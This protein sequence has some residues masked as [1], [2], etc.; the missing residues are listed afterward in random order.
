[1]LSSNIERTIPEICFK[2]AELHTDNF[3]VS[4]VRKKKGNQKTIE[5]KMSAKGVHK[6]YLLSPEAF[7]DPSSPVEKVNRLLLSN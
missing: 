3:K 5:L 2:S 6:K 4:L 1:M 7:G